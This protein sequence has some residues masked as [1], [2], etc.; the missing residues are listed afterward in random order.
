MF[1][2]ELEDTRAK[3]LIREMPDGLTYE[4]LPVSPATA[5]TF[6]RRMKSAF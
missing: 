6:L 1:M 2:N 3:D 4:I 5:E